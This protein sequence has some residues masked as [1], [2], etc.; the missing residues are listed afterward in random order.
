MVQ[1][2]CLSACH[3]LL[4]MQAKGLMRNKPEFVA[5]QRQIAESQ[6]HARAIIQKA[7]EVVET[8]QV[9]QD[10]NVQWKVKLQRQ[11]EAGVEEK[12][13]NSRSQGKEKA[14]PGMR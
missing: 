8:A 10:E 6:H 13:E 11:W 3:T 7:R 9:L 5:S 2:F 12:E 1:R 14:P 4:P